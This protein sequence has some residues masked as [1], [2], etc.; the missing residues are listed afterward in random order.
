MSQKPSQLADEVG[1]LVF[2]GAHLS[3]NGS[4]ESVAAEMT[5]DLKWY[6]QTQLKL[7]GVLSCANEQK[8]EVFFPG[9]QGDI[10]FLQYPV[11]NNRNGFQVDYKKETRSRS[12]WEHGSC[13]I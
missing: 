7:V 4:Q 5:S 3:G 11:N 1:C 2:L 10:I 6:D 12:T 13:N 8:T 9:I